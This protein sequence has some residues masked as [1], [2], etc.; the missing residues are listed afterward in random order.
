MT[1]REFNKVSHP[2]TSNKKIFLKNYNTRSNEDIIIDTNASSSLLYSYNSKHNPKV[3]KVSSETRIKRTTIFHARKSNII[4]LETDVIRKRHNI[5]DN[6]R[7]IY[8]LDH[9]TQEYNSDEAVSEDV[10]TN[11]I[12]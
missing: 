8:T 4:S 11:E 5:Y 3:S 12:E 1:C 6:H 7:N 2:N 9:L 10:K